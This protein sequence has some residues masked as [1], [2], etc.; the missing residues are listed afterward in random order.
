[1]DTNTIKPSQS[2]SIT[3]PQHIL[4]HIPA[5]Y[6]IVIVGSGPGGLSAAARCAELKV[7][8]ILLE[9]EQH[10]SDTIFKYQK[11]KHVMAEPNILPL[12]SCLDFKADKRE[13]IL[14]TWNQQ[15]SDLAVNISYGK[16]VKSIKKDPN[17]SAFTISCENGSTI[18]SRSVIL[19][20]GLQGN[21]RKLGVE[22]ENL[23][24]VQ[25]TLADPD[26]F[27]GE[28]I[29]VVG[30][31]DAGIE[32]ALGLAD[33]GNKVYLFNRGD[34]FPGVK[35]GNVALITE[36]DKNGAV[37]IMYRTSVVKVEQ[38]I[39]Q[40]PSGVQLKLHYNG[41]NGPG[42]LECHR[43]ICRLGAI[44]PRK[45]VESFGVEFPNASPMAI[46][47]LSET[48]ESNVQG[49][50]IVGALG[51]YPLIKQ[52]M[53]QGNDVVDTLMGLPVVPV[54]EALLLEKIKV[55]N[56]EGRVSEMLATIGRNVPLFAS[57]SK[58]QLRELLLDSS[59]LNLQ[60]GDL[61]FKKNDYTTTFFSIVTGAVEIDIEGTDGQIS[62]ITLSQGQYFGE[63]GLISGRRRTATVRAKH[64][65]ILLETPRKAML[66]LMA[67]VE[68]VN[69]NIDQAFIRR[70]ISTYLAPQLSYEAVTELI[71]GGVET[72]KYN[73]R[74][75]LFQEGDTAD[76]LY[77]IRKGSVTIST[78]QNDKEIILSYVTAGNYIGEMALLNDAPR[79]A[80]VT[81]TVLTEVLVLNANTFKTVLSKNPQWQA[82]MQAQVVKR[83][84]KNVVREESGT[85]DT[86]L[87]QFLMK[88]GLGEATDVLMIDEALC[89][90]C[91]N[92]ETACAE[93]HHSTS[94]LDRAAG[95]T[96][97]TIHIPTSCRHCENPHCMKDCPPDAIRRN[98]AGEVMISD[99]CIGCGNC[100]RNCPYGV[101][102]LQV[103][104]PPK[105]G[106]L[107]SWL[108]FGLGAAPGQR[109]PEYDPEATKKAVKCDLC[110]GIDGG[111]RCVN[112]CPTGAAIRVS[113]EKVIATG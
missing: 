3:K 64:P 102:Q 93:T 54:D 97:E 110:H 56:P 11:G 74:Q 109:A 94:R 62:P 38:N 106:G 112:A 25:Y 82:A 103:Q 24:H 39:E 35:D 2:N 73:A 43:M 51:G 46:P 37:K 58:L 31:G 86:R 79:S 76:E 28:T 104:K 96:F 91:N 87:I 13:A 27:K 18:T 81:A 89:I 17:T 36:A 10:A 49:L 14:S 70:A 32:N 105:P 45:L 57:M 6:D 108:L 66:K 113:P 84:S 20:I 29:V 26:E 1:M 40:S 23:A 9:A 71:T 50:Y 72:R 107:W 30:A 48:Y 111:P 99:A 21:V 53:N 61:V 41:P 92:C 5:Q 85:N 83:V 98:E 59:L 52:A 8:H 16:K 78:K 12:R 44:A 69:Q 100:E 88:Q 75:V 67:S 101:I 95:F 15:L 7:K 68:A 63:M 60:P 34:E 19:G 47:I 33:S 42:I 80:T 55:C 65:C 77:L 4:A 90:H 22:G